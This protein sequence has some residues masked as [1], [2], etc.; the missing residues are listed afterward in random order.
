MSKE[1]FEQK[2][3]EC[4]SK[5]ENVLESFASINWIDFVSKVLIFSDDKRAKEIISEFPAETQKRIQEKLEY[6]KKNPTEAYTDILYIMNRY[7]DSNEDSYNDLISEM[8][9]IPFYEAEPIIQ[10]VCKKNIILAEKIKSC[11]IN[12]SDLLI[13][14]DRDIQKI[15]RETD[16]AD[17]AKALKIAS[18]EIQDK[19]FRN[20]S[21]RAASILKED[22]E[23]LGPIRKKDAINSQRAIVSIV[24][25]LESRG[26]LLL[27]GMNENDYIL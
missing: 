1:S 23:F 6:F 16:S 3:A 15:L 11:R 20:M 4:A 12:F 25:K 21:K 10:K 17:L 14:S 18:P 2:M 8:H 5:I 9:T 13:L 27:H 22:I 7:D 24:K 26:E 19:I